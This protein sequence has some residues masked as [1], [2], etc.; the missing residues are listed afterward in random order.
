MTAADPEPAPEP[1]NPYAPPRA[2][3]DAFG[4]SDPGARNAQAEVL[5]RLYRWRESLIRLLGGMAVALGM[6]LGVVGVIALG[7]A[8]V[9]GIFLRGTGPSPDEV[10]I[11]ALAWAILAPALAGSLIGIGRGLRAL[12]PWARWATATAGYLGL[13]AVVG[14]AI[15]A[16]AGGGF[17]GATA[18]L[19]VLGGPIVLVLALVLGPDAAMVFSDDYRELVVRSPH[20]GG[21]ADRRHALPR[22]PRWAGVALIAVIAGLAM[23]GVM[24]AVASFLS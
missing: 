21:K 3:I 4:P 12:R 1:F 18:V 23:I 6:L 9:T 13:M 20:P 8:I 16:I 22:L 17:A 24:V 19:V 11:V 14:L 15:L 10:W 2:A 5:R 7:A